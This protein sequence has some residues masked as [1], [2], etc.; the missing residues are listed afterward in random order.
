MDKPATFTAA[1]T[2]A[3]PLTQFESTLAGDADRPHP[4]LH[5]WNPAERP[6]IGLAIE[7]DGTWTHQGGAFTRQKLVKLFASVLRREADGRYFV[8]TPVEKVPVRVVDAPFMAVELEVRGDGERQKLIWR[9]NVDDA[10]IAGPDHPIRFE[11]EASDGAPIPYVMIRDGLEARVPRSLYYDLVDLAVVAST[12]DTEQFG[13]WSAGKFF[14]MANTADI[15][16]L[17][18]TDTH[19]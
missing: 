17:A 12:G 3:D 7:R 16:E 6:D 11:A 9:T 10:V 15:P 13:V 19:A 8:V 1:A 14:A 2:A 5:L 4:P 18:A